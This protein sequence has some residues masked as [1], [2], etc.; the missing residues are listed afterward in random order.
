MKENMT[1]PPSLHVHRV[2]T[3]RHSSRSEEEHSQT[4]PAESTHLPNATRDFL[5]QLAKQMDFI[6]SKNEGDWALTGSAAMFLWLASRGEPCRPPA[7][8]DVL[9]GDGLVST[10]ATN[11]NGELGLFTFKCPGPG[12][13][14]AH[15]NGKIIGVD[16][17]QEDGRFGWLKDAKDV[18]GIKVIPPSSLITRKENIVQE[19]GKEIGEVLENEEGLKALGDLERLRAVAGVDKMFLDA[20]LHDVAYLNRCESCG[21]GLRSTLVPLCAV[22]SQEFRNKRRRTDEPNT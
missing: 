9:V 17:L 14:L 12:T 7:D 11:L 22:C 5:I 15:L 18:G 20:L 8:V 4:G 19:L 13:K 2:G 16:V 3:A 10:V 6:C 21:E 1:R